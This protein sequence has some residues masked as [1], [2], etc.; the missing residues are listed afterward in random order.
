MAKTKLVTQESK[1]NE[2]D[3]I[4]DKLH[5][6]YILDQTK[7]NVNKFERA[8]IIK[9]YMKKHTISFDELSKKIN[10]GKST[11]SGWLKWNTITEDEYEKLKENGMSESE[12]FNMIKSPGKKDKLPVVIVNLKKTLEWC[13]SLNGKKLDNE[14]LE[15]VRQ[16][17]NELNTI[18]YRAKK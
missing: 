18:I 17:R 16:L 3:V 13:K 14:T 11:L 4:N 1:E 5:F 8:K 9:E 12:I 2:I 10:I 7:P 6:S 15:L